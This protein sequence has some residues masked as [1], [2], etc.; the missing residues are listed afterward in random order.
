MKKIEFYYGGE[1]SRHWLP[2]IRFYNKNEYNV[3]WLNISLNTINTLYGCGKGD[4]DSYTTTGKQK[5]N[6][7]LIKHGWTNNNI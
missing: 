1:D 4:V 6:E 5:F 3:L 7:S 2:Y